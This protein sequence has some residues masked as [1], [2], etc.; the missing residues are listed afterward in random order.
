MSYPKW[1]YHKT[2]GAKLFNSE[3][4]EKEAGADWAD[5]PAK[6]EEAPAQASTE[7]Q[8]PAQESKKSKGK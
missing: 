6:F 7:T 5:T 3:A 4:E 2:E 1:L 8:E